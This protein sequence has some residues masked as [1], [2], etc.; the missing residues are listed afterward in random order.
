M[1]N[2]T[3]KRIGYL[4][5]DGL[6][7]LDLFGPM[8]AFEEANSLLP[9]NKHHYEQV[10][11]AAD[12]QSV[13]M[14]NGVRIEPHVTL[15]DCPPLHTLIVPGGAGTRAPSFPD[16]AIDWIRAAAPALQRYGSICTGLY[17][18]ARTGLLDGHEVTTH[19]FHTDDVQQRYPALSV[20]PDALFLKSGKVFTAAGVTSGIDLALAL[21]EEDL[22]PSMA[23]SVA[24]HL[25]VFLKRPGGQ[26]QFSTVL[27]RQA[28]ADDDYADLIAW[29][30]DNLTADLSSLA[31]ADRLAVSERQFRRRFVQLTGE[32]PTQHIERM[33]IEAATEIL[34]TGHTPVEVI[35]ANVGYNKTDTFRRA[36]ERFFGISPSAYRE[37]FGA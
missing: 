34:V 32:T 37:R 10:L 23:S 15:A 27:E 11:V 26:K 19:W 9:D 21:I 12:G 24:K 6:Q 17:V 13:A 28:L 7:A 1:T 20:V 31:L 3:P 29:I 35:A 22:G 18:L 14:S 8:D 4:V 25:V 33:R 5:F 36:F 30:A 2:N 16:I